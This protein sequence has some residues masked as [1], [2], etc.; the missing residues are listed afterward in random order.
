MSLLKLLFHKYETTALTIRLYNEINRPF[1]GIL[2]RL[3]VISA[4]AKLVDD[5]KTRLFVFKKPEESLISAISD[6]SYGFYFI[7]L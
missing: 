5:V 1:S 7:V 2:I 3:T 6:I 4:E